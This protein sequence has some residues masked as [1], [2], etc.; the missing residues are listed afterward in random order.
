MIKTRTQTLDVDVEIDLS[1]FDDDELV[2]EL[3]GRGISPFNES[4]LIQIFEAIKLNQER[5]AL[6]LMRTFLADKYGVVL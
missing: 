3:D 2:R 1:E 5:K 6:D 4:T